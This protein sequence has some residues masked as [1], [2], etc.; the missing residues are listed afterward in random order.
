MALKNLHIYTRYDQRSRANL[1]YPINAVTSYF[2]AVVG[3]KTRAN[4]ST[5][6]AGNA[7]KAL[8][9]RGALGV[10]KVLGYYRIVIGRCMASSSLD[11]PLFASCEA[12]SFRSILWVKG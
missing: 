4:A 6:R 1:V 10:L 9:F 5:G 8:H 12:R 3:F 7:R 11:F 2:K